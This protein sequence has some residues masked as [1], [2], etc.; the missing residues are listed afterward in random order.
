MNLLHDLTYALINKKLEGFSEA[1]LN[2]KNT[3][4]IE[5]NEINKSIEK[6]PTRISSNFKGIFSILTKNEILM[7]KKLN[8]LKGKRFF[9]WTHKKHCL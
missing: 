6:I 5:K 2:D 4:N 3:L 1:F 8:N 9:V 7:K